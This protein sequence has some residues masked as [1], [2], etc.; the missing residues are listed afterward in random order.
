MRH[1]APDRRLLVV[2]DN[3]DDVFVLQIASEEVKP[4]VQVDSAD[5]GDQLL[6]WVET[7]ADE[8]P[9]ILLVDWNLPG[10]QTPEVIKRIR[11][12]PVWA[13]VPIVVYSGHATQGTEAEVLALGADGFEVKPTDIEGILAMIARV[14]A[15]AAAH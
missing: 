11:A 12:H 1:P 10:T 15:L 4:P 2:D 13:T 6:A 14:L 8:P 3:P 5:S 7:G 9:T